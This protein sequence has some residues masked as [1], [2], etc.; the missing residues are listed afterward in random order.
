[1]QTP[2]MHLIACDM[3]IYILHVTR[4]YIFCLNFACKY[5]ANAMA[6][7]LLNTYRIRTCCTHAARYY[8]IALVLYVYDHMQLISC[9]HTAL[10][11]FIRGPSYFEYFLKKPVF[12]VLNRLTGNY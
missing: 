12:L 2:W 11:I 10:K 8:Q 5:N 6:A 7:V 1:M 9:M 3:H 4:L